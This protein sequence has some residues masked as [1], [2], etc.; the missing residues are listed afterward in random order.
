M[1]NVQGRERQAYM[2]RITNRIVDLGR[3]PELPT[4]KRLA[5]VRSDDGMGRL[6]SGSM[7]A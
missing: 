5:V 6:A 7:V 4:V 3:A 2:H 1:S